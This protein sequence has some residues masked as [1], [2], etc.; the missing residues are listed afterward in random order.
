V[1]LI[2]GLGN[3]GPRYARTRHNVGFRVV[4]RFAER[5]AIAL[6]QTRFSSRFGRGRADAID[7]GLLQPQEFMNRSGAAVA[8]ALRML[9]VEDAASDLLVVFDDLDLPFAQ[10]R[11]RP[12]GGAGG[13]R[14]MEDVIRC[15]GEG[16]A[17]LR[18]GIGRPPPG[19]P[20]DPVAWVLQEFSAE[21]E[22]ALR[23]AV[24]AAAHAVLAWAR[25]GVQ[26]AMNAVNRRAPASPPGPAEA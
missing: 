21:E 14:G 19:S 24:D 18:F 15:L 13:H 6:S 16:F 9:P 3:P 23:G 20:I 26:A 11:L 22:A 2:V 17:R 12:S 4:E 25:D 10:L 1:K 8:E 5:H 7:V